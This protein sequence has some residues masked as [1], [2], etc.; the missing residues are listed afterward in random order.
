[1]IELTDTIVQKTHHDEAA[2]II[3]SFVALTGRFVLLT[4]ELCSTI[5]WIIEI[6]M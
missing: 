4:T 6:L 1:M 3:G 2:A 5:R